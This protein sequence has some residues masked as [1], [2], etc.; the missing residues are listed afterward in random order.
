MILWPG[1]AILWAGPAVPWAGTAVM[2]AGTAALEAAR[3]DSR[4]SQTLPGTPRSSQELPEAARSWKK[5]FLAGFRGQRGGGAIEPKWRPSP[6]PPPIAQFF[7]KTIL[8]NQDRGQGRQ[9]PAT[10]FAQSAVADPPTHRGRACW[11]RAS[12]SF[13]SNSYELS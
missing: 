3:T 13:K 4:C 12:K 7:K 6:W 1:A 9:G 11:T 5:R 2:W 10:P 8:T